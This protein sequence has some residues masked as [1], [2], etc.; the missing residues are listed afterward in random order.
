MTDSWDRAL[1]DK[2][3]KSILDKKLPVSAS[4]ITSLQALAISHPQHHNYIVHCIIRFIET[5]PPDY[6]LAGLYVVDAISRAV[7]KLIRKNN[8]HDNRKPVEAEGYIRRFGIV[9]KDESLEG[10][11]EHCST[12]DK[13]KVKK[14][15]DIWEQGGI[16]SKD[17][18]QFL[19]QSFMKKDT[20][21]ATKLHPNSTITNTTSF[22]SS[23]NVEEQQQMTPTPAA[24][25]E[26]LLARLSSLTSGGLNLSNLATAIPNAPPSQSLLP[27]QSLQPP[28]PSSD[29][30]GL[31]PA[32]VRILGI[33]N[34][35]TSLSTPAPVAPQLSMAAIKQQSQLPPQQ[36]NYTGMMH[37]QQPSYQPNVS[38]NLAIDPRI[39]SQAASQ[40]T[41]D[42]RIQSK[43]ANNTPL[44]ARGTQMNML[45]SQQTR[46][47]PSRWNRDTSNNISPAQQQ[48][49]Q[50]L[51][52]SVHSQ[53]NRR[54]MRDSW[55]ESSTT[56]ERDR[57]QQ[58]QSS[59]ASPR[60]HDRQ[61]RR[62]TSLPGPISDPSLPK[63][64]I[65]VVTRTLFVGPLPGWFGKEDV[66]E[67]FEKYG[68][69]HSIIVSKKQ[70]SRVNAFLK[71]TKRSSLEAAKLGTTDLTIENTQV[72][73]NY[74]FGFGPRKLFDYEQGVSIIPLN[75]LSQ[76]EKSNLVTAPI[77]GFQ[78]LPVHDQMTIEEPEV[79][80][81]PEWKIDEKISNTTPTAGKGNA[82]D[83]GGG[84]GGG[85]RM[86][87]NNDNDGEGRG[88]RGGRRKRRR[89][90]SID[91]DNDQHF[92]RSHHD[93]QS[94]Q[95]QQQQQQPQQPQNTTFDPAL[96]Q[97][98]GGGVAGWFAP[99][100]QYQPPRPPP[101]QLQ[102]QQHQETSNIP[103]NFFFDMQQQ[104]NQQEQQMQQMQQENHWGRNQGGRGEEPAHYQQSPNNNHNYS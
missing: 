94:E 71:Y 65:R 67:I 3:L 48:Q 89:F 70:K 64:S 26:S 74:G 61:L 91:D 57:R 90:D 35:S 81:R 86:R 20:S 2:E 69:V 27:S 62:R 66:A 19:K 55:P 56:D 9:L 76:D 102:S 52:P 30:A 29:N 100:Q 101:S 24:D 32:L 99:Q 22:L 79:E 98:I 31:P 93:Q 34:D 92:N 88:H 97:Q 47:R 33:N 83:G 13:E 49:Q 15:L 84:G 36:P 82:G 18:T 77:G 73:V 17:L 25:A 104:L 63:G 43:N 51:I 46:S 5:A 39:R 60:Q 72:K 6:R 53:N 28:P 44:G 38:G 95:Q 10:C 50:Q 12:K 37:P 59:P 78:G 42:P 1:F 4:K 85:R 40:P 54:M 23:G 75:E 45:P 87:S 7:H 8:E 41:V 11:F 16:Y 103:P 96:L 80:Y 68:E 21:G 14:T 58:R